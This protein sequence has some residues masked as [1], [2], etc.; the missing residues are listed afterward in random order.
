MPFFMRMDGLTRSYSLGVRLAHFFA[1]VLLLLVQISLGISVVWFGLPIVLAAAHNG[2]AALLLL[3]VINLNHATAR[4][5][6]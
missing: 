3:A 5:V 1:V 2:V 4:L 6:N